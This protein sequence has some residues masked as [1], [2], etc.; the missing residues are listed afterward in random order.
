MNKSDIQLL[1]QYNTWANTQIL[2]AASKVT[3]DQFVAPAPFPHGGLRSTLTHILFAEWIWRKRWE[4]TS[5]TERIKPESFETIAS[6]RERWR[7]EESNL[8]AFIE[9]L[10]E[11]ELQKEFD[12]KTTKGI[13]VRNV[14][15]QVMAHVV[16]HGTQHRSEAAA[17]LTDFGC[18]PGDIDLIVFLRGQK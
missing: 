1:Y 2:N 9:N 17:L 5:P 16:N 18:S 11:A 13:P 15:W 3:H 12:Y 7:E 14:L 8:M 10:T 4:G 6:L